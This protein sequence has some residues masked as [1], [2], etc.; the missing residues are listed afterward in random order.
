MVTI[1]LAFGARKLI[2]HHALVRN[3]PAVETLGSVTFIC[4]DKTG[5]LT[6]NQMTAESFVGAN[7]AP[8][9]SS[10]SAI[11]Q[12]LG[13][14]LALS[15]DIIINTDTPA[16]E[17]TELALFNAALAFGF[18]KKQLE[19]SMPRLAELAFDSERKQMTTLHQGTEG[20]VAFVKGAP[21]KVLQQC[22][23]ALSEQGVVEDNFQPDTM[24]N[25]A[26]ELASQ[27]YRVI[28]FEVK[29]CN[30]Y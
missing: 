6:Q 4:T 28:A 3:L 2:Q 11:Q 16:G 27:G 5:T 12:V 21:E 30:E 23:H 20:V 24:L 22:T 18:D 10:D 15:N 8:V 13:Q 26:E 25:T 7:L 29:I 1:S 14:A 17:P 9:F 19:A